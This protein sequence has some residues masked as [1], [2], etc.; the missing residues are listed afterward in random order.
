MGRA[1]GPLKEAGTT[2]IF[3]ASGDGLVRRIHPLLACFSG[4]YPEQVL[5]ACVTTGQC[6]MCP[7]A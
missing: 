6:A 2:G 7:T 4:D 3:M 1:L 5:T